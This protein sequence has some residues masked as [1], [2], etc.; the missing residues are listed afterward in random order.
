[1]SITTTA[2]EVLSQLLR[3]N[4][5][6]VDDHDGGRTIHYADAVGIFQQNGQAPIVFLTHTG[7]TYA[8]NLM[9][10][11]TNDVVRLTTLSM[12]CTLAGNIDPG[13]AAE[14]FNRGMGDADK[15]ITAVLEF[16][17]NNKVEKF[18]TYAELR[19]R[20]A[21]Q[22]SESIKPYDVNHNVK[23]GA[24]IGEIN[25]LIGKYVERNQF[26]QNVSE[27]NVFMKCIEQV[28]SAKPDLVL[29]EEIFPA[30][31][32]LYVETQLPTS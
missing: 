23:L 32:N 15:R 11:D 16:V 18:Y 29:D 19:Q 30:A 6:Y 2:I 14:E 24:I 10:I 12:G 25:D 21:D 26:L 28:K 3:S 1:M 27:L 9:A 4:G 5:A 8:I 17:K 13:I 22:V 7:G 31:W 20:A